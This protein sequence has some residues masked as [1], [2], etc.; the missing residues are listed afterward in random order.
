MTGSVDMA[1]IEIF[2][3]DK[4]AE[5]IKRSKAHKR[6]I[7]WSVL[8]MLFFSPAFGILSLVFSISARKT[9]DEFSKLRLSIAK[10]INTV[11]TSLL[12]LPMLAVIALLLI[13]LVAVT[14]SGIVWSVFICFAILLGI[15]LI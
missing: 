10:I 12:A 14:V 3:K 11:A 8:V 15:P 1:K 13:A 9:Q 5:K 4:K 7:I 6:M 2:Q